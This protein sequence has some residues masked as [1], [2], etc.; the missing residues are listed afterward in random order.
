MAEIWNKA[1]PLFYLYIDTP[2]LLYFFTIHD[3]TYLQ[4]HGTAMGTCMAPTY[5]MG[6]IERRLLC[7]FPDKPL[8]WL[9]YI[10]GIFL[11]WT[12]GRAKLET[13]IQHANIFHPTIKFTFNISS[14]H[15][16]FLDVMVRLL[17]SS[18]HTDLYS[19]PTDT[20]N[21][22]HWSSCHLQHTKRSIPYSP[23]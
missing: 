13:F 8:V 4:T 10:D 19:K 11:I 3:N 1:I 12:H 5:A 6:A 23:I 22:L 9:R 7:S 18:L 20:I 17:G 16:P 15:I 14:T 21:Y 2:H